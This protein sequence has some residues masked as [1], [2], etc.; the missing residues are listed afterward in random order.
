MLGHFQKDQTGSTQQFLPHV[1]TIFPNVNG[2]RI[3]FDRFVGEPGDHYDTDVASGTVIAE[4]RF[5]SVFKLSHV[6]RYADIHNDYDSTYA[7][8]YI[9]AAQEEMN[10]TRWK[11]ITDTQIFNQ[12]TNLEAKFATGILSHKVLGGVDY[13]NFQR[14]PSA[15]I[16]PT[17]DN[18]FNVYDPH[19]GQ[20]QMGRH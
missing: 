20:A 10:R 19:Y 18:P 3:P 2:R 8:A 16:S 14:Q 13:M 17:D 7:G 4:H 15:R 5:N 1:G 6:S 9:D 11:A 12:D